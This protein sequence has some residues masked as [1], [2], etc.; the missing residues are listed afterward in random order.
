MLMAFSLLEFGDISRRLYLYDTYA[1]MTEPTEEDVIAWNG[2]SVCEKRREEQRKGKDSFS[3]WA[4][5]KE[6]VESNMKTTG[7]PHQR[8][9]YVAGDV[10]E[11]LKACAPPKVALLRLDTDWY[12]STRTE[13]ELLYP[14]L[15][16]G[17][18]LI[19][20]DYG[21]FAGARRAVDDYFG[22]LGFLPYLSR[23][24]YTGRVMVKP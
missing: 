19:I 21:H 6:E 22:T 20:D 18:V 3:S 16:S 24:D 23:V 14:R 13:L 15:V 11:T 1:G 9:R 10:C 2:V 8:I 12:A 7:Y 4:I 5:G 17:G